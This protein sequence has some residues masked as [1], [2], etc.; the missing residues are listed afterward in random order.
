[1][2]LLSSTLDATDDGILVVDQQGLISSFNR[3]F[4]ELW[5]VPEELL[6]AEQRR[7]ERSPFVLEQLVNP[8]MFVTKI[9]ELY[10]NPE[11]ESHDVLDFNDGR[12]FE[13]YS[14]AATRRRRD[15]RPGVEL[16]RHHRATAARG[17]SSR[18]RRSTTR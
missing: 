6:L 13:R 9:A 16:P 2:S 10:A 5:R 15:R 17:A 12:V 11:A 8:E 7:G 3:R 18:T 14:E 1:M 4:V